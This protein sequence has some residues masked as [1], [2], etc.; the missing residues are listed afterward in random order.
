M[1]FSTF[2]LTVN[3][4]NVAIVVGEEAGM[5]SGEIDLTSTMPSTYSH[6]SHKRMPLITQAKTTNPKRFFRLVLFACALRGIHL[7][8]FFCIKHAEVPRR[9]EASRETGILVVAFRR[10]FLV[11]CGSYWSDNYEDF[12]RV[13]CH[14]FWRSLCSW[15]MAMN[16]P[17][18]LIPSKSYSSVRRDLVID[19]APIWTRQLDFGCVTYL[20]NVF[21]Y[22]S[23]HDCLPVVS[24]VFAIWQTESL[25]QFCISLSLPSQSSQAIHTSSITLTPIVRSN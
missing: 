14:G 10:D 22:P 25:R 6:E 21:S 23:P 4:F 1:V 17:F 2:C 12:G 9:L 19:T 3:L 8:F 24:L 15:C 20:E 16:E 13:E 5:G 11:L 7:W 18:T